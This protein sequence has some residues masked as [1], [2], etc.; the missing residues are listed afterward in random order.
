MTLALGALLALRHRRWAVAC[1]RAGRRG[2][3][4]R[5]DPRRWRSASPPRPSSRRSW[6]IDSPA[7]LP[8]GP[9]T[10]DRTGWPPWRW[11]VRRW[12]C[13]WCGSSC[14]G[15]ASASFRCR[16][17]ATTTWQRRS[18]AWST[19]CAWSCLLRRARAV[20]PDRSDV[21]GQGLRRGGWSW[22]RTQATWT[23]RVAWV[24]AVGVVLLLS[25]STCGRG[26]HEAF[27]RASTEAG[28]LSALVVLGSGRRW[29][30]PR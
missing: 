17:R 5:H 3:H 25:A 30:V 29:A 19:C 23:E 15:L 28:V 20:R 16:P 2:D 27:L 21:G 11:V 9:R 10:T 6:S 24:G 4:P 22:P 13:S 8:R 1:G 18:P 12:P 26:R 14:S 7:V